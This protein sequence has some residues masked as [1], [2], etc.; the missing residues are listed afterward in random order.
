MSKRQRVEWTGA[1]CLSAAVEATI[2]TAGTK[3]SFS[4]VSVI[5]LPKTISHRQSFKNRK[6]NMTVQEKF[7]KGLPID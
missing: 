4:K 1:T 3:S 6:G 7:S 2:A 5:A